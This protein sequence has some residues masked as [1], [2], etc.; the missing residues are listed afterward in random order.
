[1]R[2]L[3]LKRR[4]IK[5]CWDRPTRTDGYFFLR[6]IRRSRL[7]DFFLLFWGELR[8]GRPQDGPGERYEEDQKKDRK[9]GKRGE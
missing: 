1:M 6:T 2:F 9:R 8:S 4:K 5:E 7:F 3:F